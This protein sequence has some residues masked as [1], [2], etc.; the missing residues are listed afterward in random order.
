MII[1]KVS[2]ENIK[3]YKAAD[4]DLSEGITGIAGLNGSGKSTVL[5]AIGYALFDCLPYTQS[6]FVRKGEKT[7]RISVTFTGADDVEY[8]VTR[9]CGASQSYYI[10]NEQ[11]VRLYEGKVDVGHMLCDVLGYKVNEIKQL[12]SLFENAIGVLQG[13]FVS[14]F[15]ESKDKRKA[16]FDPL[17]RVEEY[18]VASRNML[19]LKNLVERR[20]EG[21]ENDK[22]FL[23]G[24][25]DKLEPL[26]DEHKRLEEENKELA[27]QVEEKKRALNDA[28][29]R[30]DVLDAIEKVM[31]ELEGQQKVAGAEHAGAG[32]ELARARVQFEAAEAAATRLKENEPGF[33]AYQAKLEEK[34]GLEKKRH[35][36]EEIQNAIN[37]IHTT[38][39]ELKTRDAATD[40]TLA[41]VAHAEKELPALEQKAAEQER[42][43]EEKARTASF[44]SAKETELAQIRDRMARAKGSQGNVCPVL[45]GVECTSVKDFSAYFTEQVLRIEGERKDLKVKSD[46]NAFKI[47]ALGN[48]K[49]ELAVRQETVKKR[50]KVQAEKS[51]IARDMEAKNA[52]LMPLLLRLNS[53]GPLAK[54]LEAINSEIRNLKPHY[55]AY[56][57]NMK[58][59]GQKDELQRAMA[60]AAASLALFDKKLKEIGAALEEKAKSYDRDGHEKAKVACE[61]LSREISSLVSH[62]EANGRRIVDIEK[63]IGQITRDLAKIEQIKRDQD[64]EREYLRFI[65]QSRHILKAAGPEI[66]KVYIDYISRE[67]TNMYCEIAGDRRVELRWTPDYEIIL[68]AD[69]R[70]HG[71]RQLSGGEQMSAALA[72]RL[73]ILKI[74]TSSDVVFL[75]EPTQNMDESR[76][77]NLAQEILRIKG[78][79]QMVVISH[80]DT[81]NA[82][83]ENVVEIEKVNGES[84]VRGRS[85]AG[86]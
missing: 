51:G 15:L 30:K 80:D 60:Q 64:A 54:A 16:I 68:I 81:F 40:R 5:E 61:T 36:K 2:L 78:F 20:I 18:N 25:A 6:E 75:D 24:R 33:K 83:L 43:E 12:A 13:T 27:R 67:A 85:I 59:A 32:R 69:G 44:A 55:E 66:V 71:F 79:K 77:Q 46:E 49:L 14:E 8:T 3:S 84:C 39:T 34:E 17:L 70:E 74:L 56:Q 47:K 31:R 82:N 72:V 10:D 1:R 22:K 11:G 48:P 26:K 29:I 58:L 45:L 53:L 41:E 52:E 28:R 62:G 73:A 9:K 35:E 4:I 37:V 63:D 50:D 7:G 57:Q 21:M 19:P 65:D 38:L 42:L 23:E 86:P 76:R